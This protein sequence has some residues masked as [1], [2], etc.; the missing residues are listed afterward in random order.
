MQD[1]VT[2]ISLK[3]TNTI[4][5]LVW[6]I[7]WFL[8]GYNRLLKQYM[9][10]KVKRGLYLFCLFALRLQLLTPHIGEPN[11]A[12]FLA[13]SRNVNIRPVWLAWPVHGQL[14]S[15]RPCSLTL[16]HC[17]RL[18]AWQSR[19]LRGCSEPATAT[20]TSYR[21]RQKSNNSSRTISHIYNLVNT[22]GN[23]GQACSDVI[24][25]FLKVLHWIF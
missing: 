14:D 2:L 15:A 21:D 1:K 13:D 23:I 20:V 25:G 19:L 16:S 9:L 8:L 12:L 4:Y 18:P 5:V 7:L 24:P 3:T 10:S 6:I 22:G 11:W 17:D